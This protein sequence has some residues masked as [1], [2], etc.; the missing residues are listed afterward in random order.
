MSLPRFKL[1]DLVLLV[2]AVAAGIHIWNQYINNFSDELVFATYLGL[3]WI[4]TIG[5]LARH[6]ERRDH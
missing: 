3:L 4:A 6:V 1:L 5:T 2:A